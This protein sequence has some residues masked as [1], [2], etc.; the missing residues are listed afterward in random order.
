MKK[1]ASS[2]LVAL[3][4]IRKL[5]RVMY[6]GS[7]HKSGLGSYVRRTVECLRPDIADWKPY[8]Q[9]WIIRLDNL[10][11]FDFQLCWARPN[12]SGVNPEWHDERRL[13]KQVDGIIFLAT[14]FSNDYMTK[15]SFDTFYDAYERER[16]DYCP[17]IVHGLF[18][19]T[20]GMPV[21]K[22]R[23]ELLWPGE[24][25]FLTFDDYH[26]V[27]SLRKLIDLFS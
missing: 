16:S 11:G 24:R 7:G 8:F 2:W 9:D 6:L 25:V 21:E 5:K 3:G 27:E 13:L 12:F 10:D 20:Q 1:H 4:E 23:D 14:N 15:S 17:L 18:S 19:E 22:L 26:P